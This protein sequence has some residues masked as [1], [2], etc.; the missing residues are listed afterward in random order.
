MENCKGDK[1]LTPSLCKEC[2]VSLRWGG[3]EE[4]KELKGKAF[5]A[6]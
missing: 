4:R 2:E 1:K 3:D 6:A 5:W